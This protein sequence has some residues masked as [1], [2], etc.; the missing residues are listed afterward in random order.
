M[1]YQRSTLKGEAIREADRVRQIEGDEDVMDVQELVK[2]VIAHVY[3]RLHQQQRKKMVRR[4][5]ERKCG[6]ADDQLPC[7]VF[8]YGERHWRESVHVGSDL[9]WIDVEGGTLVLSG[10][11]VI[12]AS[13]GT[14][15]RLY[16]LYF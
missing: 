14:G 4:S 9:C 16:F 5:L 11:P 1:G 6:E 7:N 12:N 2:S 3:L 8:Q 15:G 13:R 10:R